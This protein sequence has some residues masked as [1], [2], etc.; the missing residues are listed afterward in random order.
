VRPDALHVDQRL[1]RQQVFVGRARARVFVVVEA[2]PE[3]CEVAVT[4][5]RGEVEVSVLSEVRVAAFDPRGENRPD[6]SVAVRA[7]SRG[8]ACGVNSG[9]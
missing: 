9:D 4:D 7:Q 1:L 5:G 8:S 3:Q 6:D 2:G